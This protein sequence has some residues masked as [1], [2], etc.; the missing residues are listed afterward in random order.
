MAGLQDV[1]VYSLG[2]KIANAVKLLVVTS[3][4]LAIS[5]MIFK[6][7]DKEGNKRFYSKIM[8]YS[9]FVVMFVILAVSLFSIEIV[10]VFSSNIFYWRS[11]TVIPVI[12]LSIFFGML[13]DASVTGLQITKKTKVIGVV[14]LMIALLNLGLNIVFI[15][16]MNIMGAAVAT[17]LSQI[18]FFI[19]ILIYAQKHYPIPYELGKI[20]K[21]VITG[22]VLYSLSLLTLDSSLALRLVI[23]VVILISFPFMLWVIGFYDEIEL[24]TLKNAWRSWKNPGNWKSNLK[25]YSEK[26]RD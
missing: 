11:H 23:K 17:L 4:Q 5:P 16:V 20:G 1:G 13:K 7:M 8:T 21:L 25:R 22:M 12:S 2:F 19:V 26:N 10:K 15:P 9:G 24:D 18:I 3:I 6:M 14:I